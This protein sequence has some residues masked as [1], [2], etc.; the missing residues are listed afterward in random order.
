MISEKKPYTPVI[1]FKG[2]STLDSIDCTTALVIRAI[3]HL[4]PKEIH[5]CSMQKF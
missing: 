4:I 5:H 2:N 1:F 3:L